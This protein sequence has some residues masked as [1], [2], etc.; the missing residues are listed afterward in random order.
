[1]KATPLIHFVVALVPF[2][3]WDHYI[4]LAILLV[5]HPFLM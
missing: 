5:P 3:V 4:L 1:M 2:F